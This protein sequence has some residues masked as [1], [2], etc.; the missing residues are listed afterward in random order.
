MGTH[1]LVIGERQV[2]A[3]G[4]GGNNF[5]DLLDESATA[6][7]VNSALDFGMSLIDTAEIY[8]GGQSEV[9][10]GKAIRSRREE[11]IIA[12]KFGNFRPGGQNIGGIFD[13]GREYIRESVEASL[14]RLGT[15]YI[16]LCQLHRVD[17]RVPLDV[18]IPALA[19][20]VHEGKILAYGMCNITAELAVRARHLSEQ[21]GV[22]P[23]IAVQCKYNLIDRT[24]ESELIPA[25]RSARLG[26]IAWGPLAN[27]LLTGKYGRGMAPKGSRLAATIDDVPESWFAV[28]DRLHAFAVA[29]GRSMPELSLAALV[30]RGADCVIAGATSASQVA[31][32]ARA[33]QWTLSD[34]ELELLTVECLDE[35][36]DRPLST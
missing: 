31:A 13:G 15:D 23:P 27:G 35:H 21:M 29:H 6:V 32:N 10:I 36:H 26:F 11:A 34:S 4:L 12:T 28:I 25:C 2:P 20:L 18:A 14:Q 33:A 9:F 5:G 17:S 30:A 16:D 3:I 1:G 19:E 24:A 22:V 7:V 8:S